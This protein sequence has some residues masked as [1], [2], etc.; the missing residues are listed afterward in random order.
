MKGV[1]TT[2]KLKSKAKVT[3]VKPRAKPKPMVGRKDDTGKA[4]VL[5]MLR[6][7][8]KALTLVSKVSEYGHNQYGEK[9]NNESWD[10]WKHVDN[11]RFRYEQ[12][13]GRHSLHS[14][15][16]LDVSGFPHIAHAAWNALAVLELLLEE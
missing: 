5:Q 4:P 14:S 6:Q 9:E 11:A 8:P 2:R 1:K 3:K 10:N 16:S 15:K 12:A 7:F 13:L